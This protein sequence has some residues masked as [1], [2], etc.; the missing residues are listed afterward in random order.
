[1]MLVKMF[2]LMRIILFLHD[3]LKLEYFMYLSILSFLDSCFR[4]CA[5]KKSDVIMGCGQFVRNTL[6]WF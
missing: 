3:P 2:K 1:M 4:L 5:W 6:E